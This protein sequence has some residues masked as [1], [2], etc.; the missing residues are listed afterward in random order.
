MARRALQG[1]PAGWT[2]Q[3]C[4]AGTLR[5]RP[6]RP[7]QQ[8]AEHSS[9]PVR[10]APPC[11]VGDRREQHPRSGHAG[12]ACGNRVRRH[13]RLRR[14]AAAPDFD[15]RVSRLRRE[16]RLRLHPLGQPDAR[17]AGRGASRTWSRAPARWSPRAAW[18]RSP[19][20]ATS[21]PRAR[22][23]SRRTTA[24]AA[25]TGCSR[26][27]AAAVSGR[28]SSSISATRPRCARRCRGP[29][30]WCGS[31]RRAIRCCASPISPPWPRSD[32]RAA[33]WWPST[34]PF[35]RPAGSSPLTLGA[36][37][38]VHS[39]TKYLNGHSDVVGGAVVAR[40]RRA[41]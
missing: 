19:W 11:I 22:A 33:R 23:S 8:Q 18:P 9:E 34:T 38:V 1:C 24:T 32:T 36:D 16:A 10:Q 14:A 3:A 41:A 12:G 6:V 25:P 7:G 28:S 17:P 29:R 35:C 13:D 30:R 27:G 37:L 4:T 26:P 20:S 15:V 40:D 5:G 39:T 31:R 21:C 2:R